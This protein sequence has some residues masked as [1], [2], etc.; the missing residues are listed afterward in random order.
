M[1][2]SIPLK[3]VA[4]LHVLLAELSFA[5]QI[6]SMQLVTLS[7]L[8]EPTNICLPVLSMNLKEKLN[9]NTLKIFEY[10]EP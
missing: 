9:I 6:P 1:K 4:V 10:I 8:L 3:F 5:V 2:M 7:I